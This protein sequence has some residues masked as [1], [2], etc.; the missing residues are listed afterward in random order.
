MKKDARGFHGV[1]LML[2]HNSMG[3]GTPGFPTL[4]RLQSYYILNFALFRL[5]G[6][7]T[8]INKSLCKFHTVRNIQRTSTFATTRILEFAY[9]TSRI[10]ISS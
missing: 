1:L 6:R 9:L 4:R 3:M 2:P 10:G 5:L 7:V 8:R